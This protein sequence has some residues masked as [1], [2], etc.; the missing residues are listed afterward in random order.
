MTEI[1]RPLML[2]EF[3]RLTEGSPEYAKGLHMHQQEVL[4]G[5]FFVYDVSPFLVEVVR[6]RVPFWH[7]FTRLC[8]TVGGV[9]AV[10]GVV[11]R[12]WYSMQKWIGD[13]SSN[14]KI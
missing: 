9:F 11:D 6:S 13:K 5:I 12:A 3:P 2:P 4:P 14:A 8:S 1:F 7:F 10:L